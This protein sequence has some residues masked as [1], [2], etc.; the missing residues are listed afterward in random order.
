MKMH[1]HTYTMT[2]YIY[3][4]HR[5]EPVFINQSMSNSSS[6][7][8][9]LYVHIQGFCSSGEN[10]QII[11]EKNVTVTKREHEIHLKKN[12]LSSHLSQPFER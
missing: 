1:T 7:F 4:V 11:T 5:Y 10:S 6:S 12:V 9:L 2:L 8:M 3:L